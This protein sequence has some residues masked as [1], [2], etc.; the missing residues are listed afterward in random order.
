MDREA[1]VRE[2]TRNVLERLRGEFGRTRVL[3]LAERDASLAATVRERL[4]EDVEIVFFGEASDRAPDRCVLPRLCCSDMADLALGRASNPRLVEALRLLLSGGKVDVL[5][6]GH[7]D[8]ADTAPASLFALYESYEK[9]RASY[10]LTELKPKRPDAVRLRETL[11]TEKDVLRAKK[12]GVATL[13]LLAEAKVTPLAV[14]AARDL[15]IVL[16]KEY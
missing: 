8:Y 1:L 5:E 2:I 7:R 12:E 15:K 10:G 4:G 3:I 11:V 16:E 6:L 13:L 9:T 14:D